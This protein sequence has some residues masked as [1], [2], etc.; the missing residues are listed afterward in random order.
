MAQLRFFYLAQG[1]AGD[2]ASLRSS[3]SQVQQA[4]QAAQATTSGQST[5]QQQQQ[6]PGS[7]YPGQAR[8]FN[9][10]EVLEGALMDRLAAVPRTS[11]AF[12]KK[13]RLMGESR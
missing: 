8:G 10:S 7:V 11:E 9:V 6:Q 1:L 4:V 13:R 12:Q 5:Q 3:W 2:V